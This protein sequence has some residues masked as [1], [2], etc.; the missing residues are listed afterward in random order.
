MR[1]LCPSRP[2]TQSYPEDHEGSLRVV[3]WR[4]DRHLGSP[5]DFSIAETSQKRDTKCLLEGLWALVRHWMSAGLR[6]EP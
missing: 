4:E 2:P 3:P 6:V 1:E 5:L